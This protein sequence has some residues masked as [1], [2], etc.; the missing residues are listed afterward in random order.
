MEE[1][2]YLGIGRGRAE[3]VRD[4][5]RCR[6]LLIEHNLQAM[7]DKVGVGAMAGGAMLGK[8]KGVIFA[9]PKDRSYNLV[10]YVF[11]EKMDD[12]EASSLILSIANEVGRLV[13]VAPKHI[14]LDPESNN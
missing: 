5:A 3:V 6:R 9:V 12:D 2:E 1:K 14:R 8:E 11:V 10:A 4:Q 13:G 7:I